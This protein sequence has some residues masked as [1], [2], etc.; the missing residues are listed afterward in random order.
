MKVSLITLFLLLQSFCVLADPTVIADGVTITEIGN[1]TG[2]QDN[3]YLRVIGGTGACTSSTNGTLIVFPLTASG[4]QGSNHEIHARSYSAALAAF[5][6][7]TT[8]TV[9]NYVDGGCEQASKIKLSK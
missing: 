1:A 7:G 9:T 5:M 6:A 2:N 8:I 4:T 3:F